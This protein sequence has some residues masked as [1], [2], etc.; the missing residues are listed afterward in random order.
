MSD[1]VPLLANFGDFGGRYV[2]ETLMP[3]VEE[4]AAAWP[5][6]WSDPTFVAEY[7]AILRDYVGRPTPLTEAR[8]LPAAIGPISFIFPFVT[9][10]SHSRPAATAKPV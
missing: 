1:R 5:A 4:L 3:A 8:R 10:N 2:A 6:A 7:R 9:E